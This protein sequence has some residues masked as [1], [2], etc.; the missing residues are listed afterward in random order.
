MLQHTMTLDSQS[1]EVIKTYNFIFLKGHVRKK[2][3]TFELI[4][5]I[6]IW[7]VN[8][9]IL[10]AMNMNSFLL[11]CFLLNVITEHIFSIIL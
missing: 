9:K 7:T 11:F 5:Q 4:M 8:K 10:I 1:M 2:T 6:K 3:L